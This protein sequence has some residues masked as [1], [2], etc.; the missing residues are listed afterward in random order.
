MPGVFHYV[1]FRLSLRL[2]PKY[3]RYAVKNTIAIGYC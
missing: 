1:W 2:F 3:F